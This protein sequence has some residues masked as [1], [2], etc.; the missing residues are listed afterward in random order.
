MTPEITGWRDEWISGRHREWGVDCHATDIDF[1][2]V[3]HSFGAPKAL[4]EYK[5]IGS[6]AEPKWRD[7]PNY[8]ALEAL[9]NA[10]GIPCF[11]LRYD[12]HNTD[13][14]KV[15]SVNQ[16]AVSYVGVQAKMSEVEWVELL[17]R[18]RGLSPRCP[19][20]GAGL[21]SPVF[22]VDD[23]QVVW[24]CCPSQVAS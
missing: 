2:M 24:S 6:V 4:V 10:A 17:H 15:T 18:V 9:A 22:K 21:S 13:S 1:L 7:R 16:S 11:V 3:E 8:K 23:G 20:C 14:W 12:R 5:S 19:H